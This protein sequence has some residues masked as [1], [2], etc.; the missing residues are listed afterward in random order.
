MIFT[1]KTLIGDILDHPAAR[2]ALDRAIPGASEG[3]F[4][5]TVRHLSIYYID[6]FAPG[7]I[8]KD[9][10]AAVEREFEKLGDV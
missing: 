3:Y 10:I 4:F 8:R 6:N 7:K 2:A 1:T 9:E 5:P